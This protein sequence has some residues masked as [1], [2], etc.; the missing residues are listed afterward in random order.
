MCGINAIFAYHDDAPPIDAGELTRTRDAMRSRGPDA[1]GAWFSA[2]R[3]IALG[4]RRLSIIDVSER[5]NQP[6]TIGGMTI[7][8]NG[9]IYNYRELRVE[10]GEECETTSDTEVLLR[11]YRRYGAEMLPRLRGMFAFAIWDGAALFPARDPYGIKPL[12][13][14]D[15]GRTFRCASQVKALIAGGGVSTARDVAGIAGFYLRGHVPEPFTTYRAI[16]SLPAGSWMTVTHGGA[17]AARAYFSIAEI[18]RDAVPSTRDRAERIASAVGESV[19]YHLVS[20][21]PVGAFLSAGLDSGSVVSHT[22]SFET[23]SET[24][25]MRFAAY[26]GTPKDELSDAA[27]VARHYSVQHYSVDLTHEDVEREL[28]RA[29]EAMD[30]PTI[31]GLNS[32]FICRAAAQRG[33]K[34]ALSGTGGDELFGGYST[35][36]TIPRAVRLFGALPR[37]SRAIAALHG[38]LARGRRFSPKTALAPKYAQTYVGA[39]I[40]KRGLFM[41]EELPEVMGRDE[42]EEALRRLDLFG[43]VRDAI[44]PDPRTPFAR[45]AALESAL[46]LRSQLLR[47]LDWASMA[48]SLEVRT[49]L[50]DAFL[51]RAVAPLIV[52]SKRDGKTLMAKPPLPRD[53]QH[54]RKTGFTVP[55]REW[56]AQRHPE[57]PRL[58]GM[59]AWALYVAR[60]AGFQPA[61]PAGKDAGATCLSS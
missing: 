20:D 55:L 59:R 43:L 9:E 35:F 13:I 22:A 24:L 10:L 1:S 60:N 17:T 45:V 27:R 37:V 8:F 41:P 61:T 23:P 12:Y 6:M 30:Q 42:A 47:D 54:R 57:F 2:D 46:M 16:H 26:A 19:R 11:M 36:R 49:P 4:H 40:V 7:V 21:V 44:T 25:T 31:D 18:L 48:H 51:L 56:L 34:V 32:Y 5:A 28:P 14:A 58:F 38:K 39:Y 33:W 50:V 53:I 15:D 29:L 3:R 52:A